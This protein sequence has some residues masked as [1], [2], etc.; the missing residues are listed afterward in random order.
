MVYPGGDA[1]I[2]VGFRTPSGQRFHAL[3][4]VNS[5]VKASP[6]FDCYVFVTG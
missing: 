2:R 3:F 4:P 6:L 1:G 5:S